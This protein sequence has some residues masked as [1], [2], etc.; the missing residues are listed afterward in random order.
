MQV[1][2]LV[3]QHNGVLVAPPD[4][5]RYWQ[6]G[7]GSRALIESL[8]CEAGHSRVNSGFYGGQLFYRTQHEGEETE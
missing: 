5:A 6:C 2:P 4:W 7:C 1:N 8:K 3:F